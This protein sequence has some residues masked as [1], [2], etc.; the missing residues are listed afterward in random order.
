MAALVERAA[1][2]AGLDLDEPFPFRIEGPA[3]EVV[4]HIIFKTDDAP[5]DHA[6]HQRAKRM[7]TLER[8]PVEILG[9]Y[10]QAGG[11]PYHHPGKRVHLHV[12]SRDGRTS[13]HVD[14][15]RLPPGTT[16]Y[17]PRLP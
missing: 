14:G 4:Y 9:F 5:H 17:L 12:R 11:G 1:R 3:D 13:G 8:E 10:R 7:F 2:E 16:L 15:L 6:A